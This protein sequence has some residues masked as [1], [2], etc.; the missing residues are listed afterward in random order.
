[1]W[2]Y[3]L[4]GG[5]GQIKRIDLETPTPGDNEVV[6]EFKAAAIN[7][8]DASILAGHYPITYPRTA[9]SDGAGTIISVGKKIEDFRVG[10]NVI[11]CFYS[12]WE[13][14]SA[15]SD[16][17]RF[18]LGSETDGVLCEQFCLPNTAIVSMPEHLSFAEAATLTCSGLTDWSAL[19]TKGDLKSGEHVL[20]QG[21]GG[22]SI[23]ALQF[24]KLAGAEVTII[25]SSDE[26]LVRAKEMGADHL[27]NYTTH[28]NWA[29][30]VQRGSRGG[31]D[32]ALEV[33]GAETFGQT[34]QCMKVGGKISVIGALTGLVAEIS[35]IEVLMRHL[36][37]NAITVGHRQDF[38]AMN[39]AISN[40]GMKPV[41]ETA[42]ALERVDA[43]YQQMAKGGHF[44]KLVIEK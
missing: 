37:L 23:F 22:V 29:E 35:L 31:L 39:K 19:S 43:A 25:S 27:V 13:S 17:H 38:I 18:S 4:V 26:K 21:T 33:G 30:Q 32:L 5:P 44:G 10:D 11:S 24:A 41:I 1:M 36:Q 20:I 40:A 12:N 9:L 34:L 3:Q 16:N 7:A 14:G 42:Y 6:V 15:N 2:A 8:R 28:P